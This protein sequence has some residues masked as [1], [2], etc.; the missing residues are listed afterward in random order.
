MK[1]KQA[2]NEEIPLCKGFSSTAKCLCPRLHAPCDWLSCKVA[3]DLLHATTL[4]VRARSSERTCCFSTSWP[5]AMDNCA[6]VHGLVRWTHNLTCLCLLCLQ[7]ELHSTLLHSLAVC[8]FALCSLRWHV[9]V[10][11]CGAS[12]ILSEWFICVM[13]AGGVTR[14]S[15]HSK[16][17]SD[18]IRANLFVKCMQAGNRAVYTCIDTVFP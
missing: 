14:R 12:H 3:S 1:L 7:I 2:L 11:I 9:P 17:A 18:D 5:Q 6:V 8:D 16:T 13:H 10:S 15:I 4:I